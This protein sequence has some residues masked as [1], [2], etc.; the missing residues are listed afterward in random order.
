M[1]GWK[2]EPAIVMVLAPSS[3]VRTP[4][5]I[6]ASDLLSHTVILLAQT[7]GGACT[8]PRGDEQ[9]EEAE[10]LYL[11]REH[12]ACV[13]WRYRQARE[14]GLERVDA[15]LFAGSSGDLGDLRRLRA[16]GCP[17]ELALRIVL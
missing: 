4:T 6:S 7:A 8:L 1:P 12:T 9:T 17:P 3:T 16:R 10:P 5:L 15:Q 11:D 13:S 14:L 2:F